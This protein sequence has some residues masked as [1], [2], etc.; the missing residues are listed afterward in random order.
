MILAVLALAFLL[1]VLLFPY[2]THPSDMGL[3]IY[4]GQEITRVGFNGF[5][6]KV[7]WTDYLPF[8][9][10]FLWAVEKISHV[11]QAAPIEYL[12]KL[13]PALADVG[14]TFFLYKILKDKGEKI[15]VLGSALYAFNPSVFFNSSL[16]GQVDGLGAFL[17]V[18]VFYY[19]LKAN[20]VLGGILLGIA[21]TFKPIFVIALPVL[22]VPLFIEK[23][24][25][26]LLQFFAGAGASSWLISF[27]F[28]LTKSLASPLAF[29]VKPY[30]LLFERYQVA[31]S[32][33]PYTSVN[34]FN[35]WAIGNNWWRTDLEKVW[36]VSYQAWGLLAVGLFLLLALFL[37]FRFWRKADRSVLL[38]L[39]LFGIFLALFVFATRAHERHMLT[40][41]PFLAILAATST[42]YFLVYF[43]LS[44]SYFLNLYFA[45]QWLL[46]GGKYVFSWPIINLLSLS[47]TFVVL[48][49]FIGILFLLLKWSKITFLHKGILK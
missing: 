37:V 49:L 18:A 38:S 41:L 19:L 22:L 48:V 26:K 42:R 24:F 28:V 14:T 3:W 20:Y 29:A 4:W 5:F 2:W 40:A 44:F 10:Y 11:I 17:M 45:L 33:Y 27:P 32:Q 13:P 43:F 1:R 16:W 34:A 39:A 23:D 47:N 8:Y 25:R 35:F 21:V 7:T 36:G 6:D 12:H 15:A 9:F 46:Q 30:F 31:A